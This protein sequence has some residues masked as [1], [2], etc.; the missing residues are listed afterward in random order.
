M[1]YTVKKVDVWAGAIED[2]VGGL[3]A[4][5]EPLAAAGTNFEFAIARRDQPGTGLVFVEPVKGAKQTKAAAAAGLAKA[6]EIGAL[7]VAGPDKPGLCA[8]V[9][10]ALGDAGISIRAI[11]AM[12]VGKQCVMYIAFDSADDAAKGTKAVSKALSKK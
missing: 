11:S 2:K 10:K 3:A 9:T 7:K 8:R 5:L 1:P 12:A 4:K 6:A